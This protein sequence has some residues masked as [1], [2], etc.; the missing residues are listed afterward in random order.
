MTEVV[1]RS[2]GLGLPS[3]PPRRA[4]RLRRDLARRR[5]TTTSAASAS[6]RSRRRP[7]R[8]CACTA[9]S[10]RTDPD[11]FVVATEVVGAT[12]EER[13]V[14]VRVGARPRTALVPLD[15]VRLAATSRRPASAA[16]SWTGCMPE[17]GAGMAM[18]TATDSAQPISN[19]LYCQLR[20]RAADPAP[21]PGRPAERPDAFEPAAVRRS[22]RSRSRSIAGGPPGGAG[23]RELAETVD[24]LDRELL[25]RRPSD[26][27]PLPARGVA[28]RLALPRP[29]RRTGRLRLRDRGGSRGPGRGPRRGAHGPGPWPP[30]ERG[31]AARRVRAVAA[32]E[33]RSRGRA[34]RCGPGSASTSSPSCCAG[35]D[36]SRTSPGTSRSRRACSD[37]RGR[38]TSGG[39]KVRCLGAPLVTFAGAG[40]GW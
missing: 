22:R 2:D 1:S 16:R 5:S 28:T 11:R 15:A 33:C 21:Q 8:C 39:T 19:A 32:G 31:R 10:R 4:R 23:H 27:P 36:R 38:R 13:I 20:D 35:I 37:R 29:R 12:G 7:A 25:G 17:P 14:G 34:P 24:A 6:R 26:R 40:V 9:T 18:A 3:G 30:H